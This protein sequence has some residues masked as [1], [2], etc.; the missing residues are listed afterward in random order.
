MDGQPEANL[1]AEDSEALDHIWE[2]LKP[3]TDSQHSAWK[4]FNY[5]VRRL[6]RRQPEASDLETVT[7]NIARAVM[8]WG[9]PHFK[10]I[11]S[12]NVLQEAIEPHVAAA[13]AS[14][15]AEI[16]R[17]NLSTE[18][19]AEAAMAKARDEYQALYD[20]KCAAHAA[21]IA[22]LERVVVEAGKVLERCATI[23]DRNLY[24]QHEKI[25]DVPMIARAW[26]ATNQKE[27]GSAD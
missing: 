3:L 20:Q 17:L 21:E 4:A 15:D 13:L 18:R 16:A 22:R 24:R 26:L 19:L 6:S 5:I 10:H 12:F 7:R 25:E 8:V 11:V 2:G 9:A 23:V 27:T 14:R 1:L